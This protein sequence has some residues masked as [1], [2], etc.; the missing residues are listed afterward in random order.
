MSSPLLPSHVSLI[1]QALPAFPRQNCFLLC[2]GGSDRFCLEV[3]HK[4]RGEGL[5]WSH[6]GKG[7]SDLGQDM[8]SEG[9]S[10]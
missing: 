3:E 6:G 10:G 4:V 5:G 8:D 1:P 9:N 2:L 7:N